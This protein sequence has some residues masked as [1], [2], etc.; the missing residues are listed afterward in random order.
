MSDSIRSNVSEFLQ[1]LGVAFSAVLVGETKRDDWTCDEWRVTLTRAGSKALPMSL[2]YYTGTGHRKAPPAIFGARYTPGTLAHEAWMKGAKPQ[3]P[4]AA[5]V[6]HSLI[7]DS[8]AA[9]QS[10]NDWCEDFGYDSD[11]IKAFTTYQACCVIGENMRK[12]F[13]R[14]ELETL[15]DMLQDY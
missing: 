12:L 10:F 11:S 2:P 1:T 7:L 13:S 14:T 4:S 15:R 3:A 5:D 8:S 6:L 9:D